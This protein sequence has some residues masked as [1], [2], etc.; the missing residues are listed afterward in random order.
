M[1]E[2][3]CATHARLIDWP[4]PVPVQ[5]THPR[6]SGLADPD[7]PAVAE[8]LVREVPAPL[9]A[10]LGSAGVKVERAR[11]AQVTWWPG[12]SI[13]VRYEARL[14]GAVSGLHQVVAASGRIPAGALV[15]G[16]GESEVGVW[17][18]PHDP[19]LPGLARALD[20]TSIAGLLS[21]LGLPASGVQTRLRAYRPGRRAVVEARSDGASIFL[22]LVPPA[23]AAGLHQTH[24][25]LATRLPVPDSL[26]FSPELGLVA[27]EAI[28]GVTLRR[29]LGDPGAALPSPDEVVSIGYRMPESDR[30]ARSP[31]ERLGGVVDLLRQIVPEESGALDELVEMIGGESRP[32]DTPVHGD[33]HEGQV[34]VGGGRIRGVLDVDTHGRGREGDDAATMLGHLSVFEHSS[35]RRGR[36][37]AYGGELL[38]RWDRLVDPV[39]LRLRTA[40]VVAG[41]A[42]GPFRVQL[43]NWPAETRARLRLAVRWAE[44][45]LPADERGLTTASRSSHTHPAS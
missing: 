23:A 41:L 10:A 33:L 34:L 9:T 36:V 35:G 12:S 39:D 20:P 37:A 5:P 30:P 15:V 16:N 13:T 40:A 14:V 21:D 4:D 17:W 22:K 42:T 24:R 32:A 11:I 26:G 28:P 8:L 19:A 43:S 2:L 29:A 1:R 27:L 25:D 38:S 6:T 18:V 44:S 45:S 31:L 7:L 3:S